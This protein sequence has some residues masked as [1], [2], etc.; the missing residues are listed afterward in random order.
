MMLRIVAVDST[1]KVAIAFGSDRC[2]RPTGVRHRN[3]HMMY[4]ED[5]SCSFWMS[6]TIVQSDI[7]AEN[8]DLT[9][10]YTQRA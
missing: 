4:R 3:S 8:G 2:W 10:V 1:Q 7:P 9:M 5:A 6:R